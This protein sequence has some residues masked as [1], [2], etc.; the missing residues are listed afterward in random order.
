M[1]RLSLLFILLA[2]LATTPIPATPTS[3]TAATLEEEYVR[4]RNEYNKFLENVEWQ[5]QRPQWD[6]HIERFVTFARAHPNHER[7]PNSLFLAGDAYARLARWSG[8]PED[9]RNAVKLFDRVAVGYAH[10]PLADDALFHAAELLE[11]KMTKPAEAFLLYRAVVNDY[12]DGDQV[13]PA[14]EGMVR[15]REYALPGEEL[16]ELVEP[17]LEEIEISE[18]PEPEPEPEIA[19]P[20]PEPVLEIVEPE[21]EP[22]PEPESQLAEM[23]L[24]EPEEKSAEVPP[25]EEKI[26]TPADES[27]EQTVSLNIPPQAALEPTHVNTVRRL[28]YLTGENRGLLAI[29]LDRP[30]AVEHA[31][32]QPAGGG[33][34]TGLIKIT[35][36][37]VA[38]APDVVAPQVAAGPVRRITMQATN[39]TVEI[40]LVTEPYRSY[41]VNLSP[42]PC[43]LLVEIQGLMTPES[44]SSPV[45]RPAV[46]VI[47][48]GHGGWDIGA[49]YHHLQEKDVALT[50]GRMVA[51]KL[52]K[53]PGVMVILTRESDIYL[54]LDARFALAND[55]GADLLVSLHVNASDLPHSEGIETYLYRPPQA[56]NGNGD[57]TVAQENRAG[58]GN[59]HEPHPQLPPELRLQL[60]DSSRCLAETIHARLLPRIRLLRPQA[61]DRGIKEGPLFLLAGARMPAVLIE[62][63]FATHA[64]EARLLHESAY[65]EKITDGIVQGIL[66]YLPLRP[67]AEH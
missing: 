57:T 16:P 51:Q 6:K 28:E 64:E 7:A 53:Q 38:L 12:P 4:N 52:K 31:A 40:Q 56:G 3:A 21:P 2:L 5:R 29:H 44:R 60:K 22:V 36:Y 20:E 14:M 1:R 46:V 15:L 9:I 23:E 63:G 62:V 50:V 11:T 13:D 61:S 17:S 35:L 49:D 59:R 47:D 18:E 30:V 27:D 34:E 54:P 45:P 66:D 25:P 37:D 58:A 48:P 32:R 8:Q 67:V 33:N 43:R 39:G 65:L 19:E 55:A 41:L 42:N 10:H 26:A 24:T